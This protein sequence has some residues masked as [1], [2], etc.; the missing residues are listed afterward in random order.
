MCKSTQTSVNIRALLTDLLAQSKL[1]PHSPKGV[2]LLT[3][4]GMDEDALVGP[5]VAKVKQHHVG[6][7]V[8]DR[9]GGSLL[10]AHALRDEEGVVCWCHHHLLPQ[11]KAV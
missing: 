10:E 1:H 3:C 8:V 9:E 11:P 7:D 5:Q 6:G 2:P 4:S